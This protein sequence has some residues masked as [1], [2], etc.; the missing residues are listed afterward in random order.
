LPASVMVLLS[1]WPS[2]GPRVITTCDILAF[3]ESG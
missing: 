3:Y 2:S 1:F